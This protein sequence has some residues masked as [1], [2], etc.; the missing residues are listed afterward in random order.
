MNL[1]T[2]A[3]WC[4]ILALPVAVFTAWLAWLGWI[5]FRESHVPHFIY[6]QMNGKCID[7]PWETDVDVVHMW[8]HHGGANQRWRI[9]R[10]NHDFYKIVSIL[11]KKCLEVE[12]QLASNGARVRQGKFQRKPHQLWVITRLP[13]GSYRIHNWHSGKCLDLLGWAGHNGASLGQW[14][15]DGE[16]KQQWK[17]EPPLP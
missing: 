1:N 16:S 14:Q 13:N 17:I 4:T 9:S 10:V 8:D 6:S 15:C 7:V 2:I 5:S 12:D 3:L 11:S